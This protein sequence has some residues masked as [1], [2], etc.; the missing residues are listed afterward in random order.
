MYGRYSTAMQCRLKRAVTGRGSIKVSIRFHCSC[1]RVCRSKPSFRVIVRVGC[2]LAVSFGGMTTSSCDNRWSGASVGWLAGVKR[3]LV[4]RDRSLVVRER[5]LDVRERS[6]VVCDKSLEV[7]GR[8]SE[9]SWS[10]TSCWVEWMRRR[11]RVDSEVISASSNGIGA[12]K[13]KKIDR[14]RILR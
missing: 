1:S 7:C 4:V 9:A 13:S 8:L 3:S 10:F 5:L 14:G 12:T 2:S 6:L 11:E